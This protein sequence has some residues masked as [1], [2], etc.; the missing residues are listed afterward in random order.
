MHRGM[1]QWSCPGLASVLVLL[2]CLHT[3]L[4]NSNCLLGE[5]QHAA[6]AQVNLG[7]LHMPLTAAVTA[8]VNGGFIQSCCNVCF[9]QCSHS[10]AVLLQMSASFCRGLFIGGGNLHWSRVVLLS[11]VVK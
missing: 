3:M 7:G 11:G 6:S 10:L 4:V 9:I 5:R 2:L 8:A 1:V